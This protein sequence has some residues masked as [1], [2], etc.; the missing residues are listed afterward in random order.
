MIAVEVF[1][2]PGA[3]RV[4][5]HCSFNSKHN[6]C[7][8][9]TM[10]KADISNFDWEHWEPRKREDLTA[11]AEQWRDAPS[12]TARKALYKVTGVRWSALWDLSYFDLT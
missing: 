10:S 8:Y 7:F 11:A 2:L 1:D 9:C 5:G 6:F 12:A 4:L 3:K